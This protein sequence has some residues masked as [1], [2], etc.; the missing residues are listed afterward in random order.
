MSGVRSGSL[1]GRETG[2]AGSAAVSASAGWASPSAVSTDPVDAASSAGARRELSESRLVCCGSSGFG[3]RPGRR[4]RGGGATGAAARDT[5]TTDGDEPV[6][7]PTFGAGAGI[8]SVRTSGGTGAATC[9]ASGDGSFAG[10]SATTGNG[11]VSHAPPGS[12][13]VIRAARRHGASPASMPPAGVAGWGAA[14]GG[15]TSATSGASGTAT[16][17]WR[18]TAGTN[19][20][21]P[22][23]SSA[24]SVR[25]R[26]RS[27]TVRGRSPPD[28]DAPGAERVRRRRSSTDVRRRGEQDDDQPDQDHGGHPVHALSLLRSWGPGNPTQC[29]GAVTPVRSQARSLLAHPDD[30]NTRHPTCSPGRKRPT[31]CPGSAS[32][33]RGPSR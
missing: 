6:G 9:R 19:S 13:P 29:E 18:G 1:S 8:S 14:A 16:P 21:G 17:S 32:G 24:G 23:R 2:S 20:S 3:L 4:G 10:V 22:D 30:A 15:T 25:R 33:R 7:A 11:A 26:T 28:S 27:A 31:G 5:I 12:A